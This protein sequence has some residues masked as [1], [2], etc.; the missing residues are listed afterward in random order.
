VC[1]A[2]AP[3]G[4]ASRAPPPRAKRV[5]EERERR[6][7][8]R[9]SGEEGKSVEEETD[10]RDFLAEFFPP[11]FL[12]E[13]PAKRAEGERR[14]LFRRC[15]EAV[16]SMLAQCFGVELRD[17]FGLVGEASPAL[18][19][20]DVGRLQLLLLGGLRQHQG[21]A[22]KFAVFPGSF[23]G[24]KRRRHHFGHASPLIPHKGETHCG[25]RGSEFSL[26]G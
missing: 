8:G 12:G 9:E 21:F 4:P 18:G 24:R 7:G 6:G 5:R 19:K 23:Q 25:T 16:R 14:E 20:G 22:C 15:R 26:R 1:G 2:A 13:V 10:E 3:P 11:P 17:V